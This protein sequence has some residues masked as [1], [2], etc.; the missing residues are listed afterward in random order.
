MKNATFRQLR[1][2]TQANGQVAIELDHRQMAQ[3]LDQGLCQSGQA[4]SNFNHGLSRLRC[5]GID[6][7]FNDAAVR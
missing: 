2:F 3:A 5:D 1:V 6:N 4:G 7:G